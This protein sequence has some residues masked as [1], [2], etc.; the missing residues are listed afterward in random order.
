MYPEMLDALIVI[1]G[2]VG[3]FNLPYVDEMV[4]VMN[5]IE[6]KPFDELDKL[7]D[8]LLSGG[9]GEG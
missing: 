8:E 6:G 7:L 2:G 9:A 1:E 3:E 5:K 4:E